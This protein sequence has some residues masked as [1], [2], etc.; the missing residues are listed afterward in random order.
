MEPRE[1]SRIRSY[2]EDISKLCREIDFDDLNFSN[3]LENDDAREYVRGLKVSKP[4]TLLSDKLFKPII[5]YTGLTNF[6]EGRVGE[7]WV[8]FTLES[9]KTMGFPVAVELKALHNRFGQV[10]S[11]ES[12]F[13]AMKG[14][15]EKQ[16]SNQIVKYI[17]GQKGV[18]YVILTN[19]CDVFI[20]DKSCVI[21]FEPAVQESFAKL[22][23]GISGTRNISDYLKRRTQEIAKH[24]LDKLFIRDLKKWYGYLQ[25]LRW[26]EDPKTS[27]VL[28]LN[29]LIFAL[30]L[31][32]FI[33]IDYR[34]TWDTF[35][36]AYNKWITK[37]PKKVLEMFF[38]DLDGFLYEYYDTEL[39]IP[40]N[41]ILL[42][43]DQSRENYLK[44]LDILKRVAGFDDQVAVF[45]EGLYSYSFRLIDEDVFGKSYETFLAENRKDSGIYY[46]PK[47]I[48]GHMSYKLVNEV[49]YQLAE[50][51]LSGIAD[52]DFDGAMDGADRFISLGIIDPAC[53]SGPFLIGVLRE[54]YHIYEELAKKTSWVENQFRNNSLFLPRDIED[55]ISKTKQLREKLGFNGDKVHRDLLSKIILRHI[56]GADIDPTALS[57]AKVNLWKETIKLNPKSFYFQ[58]L[59]EDENHILPDLE[60][61]FINGNSIVSLPDDYVLNVMQNEFGEE[62]MEMVKLH[63][64]YVENPT[65]SE[66]PGNI[67][68]IKERIRQRLM[69]EFNKNNKSFS[70]PLFFPLEYFFF[71]FDKSGIQRESKDRGFAGVIGNPPWNNLKPNKKEFAAKHPEIF[72]EGVSKYSMT[73]KE[74]EKFF[75]EKLS[76]LKVKGAWDSYVEYFKALSEYISANYRLQY[77]GDFSLQKVF[78]ERF[79]ELSKKAFSILIPSNFHTDEG[80]F[81]IRKEIVEKWEIRELISFENR[82]KVW[83]PDIHA[84]FK[85]DMLLVSKDKSE[86]P[87]RA[88][89]YVT[90][91]Q[92]IEEAF[93]YPAQLVK[94][95]SPDV[96][97][98]TEFRSS[99]DISIVSK[100]R[101]NYR[102]LKDSGLVLRSELHETNDKDI[103][104]EDQTGLMLYEGKM[105][106][107]YNSH[108]SGNKYRVDEELGRQRLLGRTANRILERI[109]DRGYKINKKMIEEGIKNK[110]IRMDYE[111]ERLVFRDVAGATNERTFISCV[112]PAGAFLANTL[113][114]IEPFSVEVENEGIIA[115]KPVGDYLYYIQALFNSFVLDY[116]I[117]QRVTSHLNFFFV[118]ELPIPDIH[119]DLE[120]TIINKSRQLINNDDL[121]LRAE[122]EAQIADEVFHLDSGEMKVVL[123]SFVYGNVNESLKSE[124]LKRM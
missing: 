99:A 37:G 15:F 124:I 81:L 18:E 70:T 7:G 73:G 107:Q 69:E 19:L 59:P 30:T 35:V 71:Y 64:E 118:Y 13:A 33:I 109:G 98:I 84:Q 123:D 48:T 55:R 50:E 110:T 66:I 119:G 38:A 78:A 76:N 26:R 52:N 44:A 29:K 45:S 14:E 41:S 42:K 103:F 61:N 121:I 75:S 16:K 101:G 2:L 27:S 11:L 117:R 20:F 1:N 53:G 67:Q 36:S 22:I 89:F 57:V 102:L 93:D 6:P 105:I 60:L 94:K 115:Q 54:I 77:R 96:M 91:W 40:S 97:G 47:E 65:R 100:I 122:L 28:L 90:D 4:E 51:I 49:F 88:K 9:S 104:S 108:F 3:T 24:D 21:N 25:E 62:I 116:Y 8:D 86:K 68:L 113:P 10:T 112:L 114:Y 23:E 87:F 72:G 43:L 74:F 95:M 58:D 80:T 120:R 34:Y 5:K 31:E 85:F 111:N 79:L 12:V 106:H 82:G 17:V 39:F 56:F 83:F 63:E 46:T 92:Q 32:D